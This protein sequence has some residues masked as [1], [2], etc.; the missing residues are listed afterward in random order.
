MQWSEF[1]F[2]CFDFANFRSGKSRTIS[3]TMWAVR[4]TS[5]IPPATRPVTLPNCHLFYDRSRIREIP[6]KILHL[7]IHH[8]AT[9]VLYGPKIVSPDE[10]FFTV[11]PL[12]IINILNGMWSNKPN[13]IY[14]NFT[15]GCLNCYYLNY[16][17]FNNV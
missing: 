4:V 5:D 2:K 7:K 11:I 16:I 12:N 10:T 9:S 17:L 6:L 15:S 1:P 8:V 13:F 3:L 14:E